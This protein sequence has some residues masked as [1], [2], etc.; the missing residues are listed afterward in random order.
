MFCSDAATV[1]LSRTTPASSAWTLSSRR[2]VLEAAGEALGAGSGMHV[3]KPAQT[4][5]FVGIS[6]T[7]YARMAADTGAGE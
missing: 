2:L 6:W 4:G 7:E 3:A 1:A 5:V